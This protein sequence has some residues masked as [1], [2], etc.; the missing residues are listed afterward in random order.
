MDDDDDDKSN[1]ND[2]DDGYDDNSNFN[3]D[4]DDDD[5][6]FIDDDVFVYSFSWMNEKWNCLG[7]YNSIQTI[8]YTTPSLSWFIPILK[9]Q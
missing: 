1:F 2:D 3:D 5:S 6:R 7:F 9:L 8:L 4:D